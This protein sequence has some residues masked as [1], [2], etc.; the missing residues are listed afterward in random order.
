MESVK[1]GFNITQEEI[2]EGK[3]RVA[4]KHPLYYSKLPAEEILP[5]LA[6]FKGLFNKYR[7]KI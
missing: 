5:F 3:M 1:T 7:V 2:L 6:P 4:L